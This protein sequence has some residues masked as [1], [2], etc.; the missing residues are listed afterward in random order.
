M[1]ELDPIIDIKNL[2]ISFKNGE[3]FAR[4]VNNIGIKLYKG[5]CVALI[6]ESGSGKTLTSMTINGLI[7]DLGAKL[8]ASQLNYTASNKTYNL[9]SMKPKEWLEVRGKRI[10][11]IF[12]E[13]M[14]ALNPTMKCGYQ[15]A[16]TLINQGFPKKEALEKTLYWLKEFEFENPEETYKSYPH[17]LSGGQRQRIALA[18]AVCC[19]PDILI[20]DEPTTALDTVTQKS[21]LLLLKKIQL[22]FHTSI[23]L[24]H[25]DLDL[26]KSFADYIYIMKN[27]EIVEQNTK[28][29]IFQSPQHSYTKLLLKANS[30]IGLKRIPIKIDEEIL[31]V[32]QL[33]FSYPRIRLGLF[34]K[35]PK[36]THLIDVNFTI[37][38]GEI[39]GIAG[40]SGCGKSTLSKILVQLLIWEKGYLVFK[41][42]KITIGDL[43]RKRKI[44]KNIQ[45]VFQDPTSSLN[46]RKTVFET[47]IEGLSKY[48]GDKM[49]KV[50]AL[51]SDVG[52]DKS[53]LE[54]Y[55][56]ELSGGQKQRICIARALS[57]SPDLLI[58]DESVSNL[59]ILIQN[60]I[61][62]LLSELNQKR[63]LSIIFISH[64][65]RVIRQLCDRTIIM[66]N[67]KI[68]EQNTT[69]NIF[70]SPQSNATKEM[71]AAML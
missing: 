14:T 27:G 68:V 20:A 2:S 41:N 7:H 59:D 42:S 37:K 18:I 55:P 24:I 28:E 43:R 60:Q 63:Q 25:H 71:I 9:L 50:I 22:Q 65:L 69:E 12:Q 26:V 61:L 6:G 8:T 56:H 35:S 48:D 15:I 19:E 57:T 66:E 39:L 34:K 23:L 31:S 10:G 36:R 58:C 4:V 13:P 29:N 64:D 3:G 70:L 32:N 46:P 17:Q 16:E 62:E 53:Y 11:T 47:I 45:I 40:K 54:R 21:F 52:L 49:Q 67:G 30:K 38:K 1:V 44:E 33:Y 51:L 5:Q